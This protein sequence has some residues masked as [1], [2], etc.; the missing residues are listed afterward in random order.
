M[1]DIAA[2]LHARNNLKSIYHVKTRAFEKILIKSNMIQRS[3]QR[4]ILHSPDFGIQKQSKHISRE[5]LKVLWSTTNIILTIFLPIITSELRRCKY[6]I[7]GFSYSFI[8][9]PCIVSLILNKKNENMFLYVIKQ[10]LL[11]HSLIYI[12]Q[13]LIYIQSIIN[14]IN[15]SNFKPSI[16]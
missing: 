6:I 9:K 3:F 10:P 14:P 13:I 12:L 5:N 15:I 4:C 2:L 11:M 1:C 16:F 7:P 8:K